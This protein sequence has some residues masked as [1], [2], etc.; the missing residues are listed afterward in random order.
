[1]K[2]IFFVVSRVIISLALLVFLFS[3]VDLKATIGVITKVDSFYFVLSVVTLFIIYV[4][5][6]YRWKM[7][8]VA[9]GIDVPL[10]RVVSSFSGG[11]F[12]SLFLPSTIGGDIARSVDLGSYTRRQSVVVATVLLDRLS[13]FVGLGIVSLVALIFG[14][15][16]VDEPAVYFVVFSLMVALVGL[17]LVVFNKKIY[18]KM[19]GSTYKNGGFKDTFKK[20]HSEIYFFRSRPHVLILNLIYS[21]IIQGASSLVGYFLLRSLR[22]NI[23]IIYPL[24]LTPVISVISTL[25]IS[26]GGLGLRDASSVFFYTKVGVTKDVAFAQSLLSFS[27]VVALG[28]IGGIIYVS[29]LRYRRIQPYQAGTKHNK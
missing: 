13:G 8:L 25:P 9:Q 22:L 10:K 29:T 19:N 6:L 15:R 20:L 18:N 1:M 23:N 26:I 16:F 28:L 14:C 27:L 3:K 5:A 2:K 24:V 17:L 12:F 7:L 11:I 21:I 4:F